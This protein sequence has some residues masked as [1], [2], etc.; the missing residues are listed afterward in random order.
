MQDNEKIAQLLAQLMENGQ[1]EQA[2]D[3]RQLCG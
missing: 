3:I 2:A 1:K